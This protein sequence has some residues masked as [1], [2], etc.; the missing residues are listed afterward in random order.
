MRTLKFIVEGQIIRQ[1][2]ECDFSNLVPGT[3]G[4][5]RAQF[6]FSS[7]WDRTTRVVAFYS[8]LGR[9]YP[10]RELGSDLSCVI[11]AEALQRSIFKVQ[12]IGRKNGLTLRTNKVMVHQKGG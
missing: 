11:P 12:V 4:Y 7:E 3:S 10:P 5:L 8:N 1:D 9:E 2:P 6:K